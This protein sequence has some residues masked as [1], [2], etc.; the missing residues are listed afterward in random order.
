LN[1]TGLRLYRPDIFTLTGAYSS[2]HMTSAGTMAPGLPPAA[3]STAHASFA[4]LWV[5]PV[6]LQVSVAVRSLAPAGFTV[7]WSGGRR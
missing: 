3:V 7:M 1:A 2:V 6:G 5:P 4:D